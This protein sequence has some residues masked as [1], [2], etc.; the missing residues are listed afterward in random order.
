MASDANNIKFLIKRMRSN[1]FSTKETI[2]EVKYKDLSMRDLLKIT[3][4][5]KEDVELTNKANP[6][7]QENEEKKFNDYFSD[8]KVVIKLIPLE[9]HDDYVFWAGTINNTIQFVYKVT[10][11]SSKSG[12]KFKYLDSFAVNNPDNQEII[13]R[14][15]SYYTVFF[16]YWNENNFQN[17]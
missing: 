2:N 4:S 5:L 17:I 11:D 12:V 16:K 6:F 15:E 3:R 10:P 13:K 14:I 9:V 1:D 7:D 8:L